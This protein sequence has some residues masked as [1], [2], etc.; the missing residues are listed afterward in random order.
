MHSESITGLILQLLAVL[1]LV[2]IN[3]FFVAAEFA[4]VKIR[5]TQLTPLIAKGNRRAQVARR[6]IRNL[7]SSLSA[8]QLGITL[9]SI[10]LGWIG[11]PIFSTLLG[12][13]MNSLGI[14]SA[15]VR[16]TIA[17]VVGMS[18]ITFLHICAGEQA[19]KWLAIQ[20]PLPTSLVV[21]Q[22]LAWF[23]RASYPFIWLLNY[24]LALAAPGLWDR[25]G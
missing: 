23:H 3:G 9:A 2:A 11:E 16:K 20:K 15:G 25:A 10:A 19:P 17:A 8:C 13:L 18:V 12:P 7:D 5:D 14:G 21:V 4:L 22:P 24:C 6:V 1:L